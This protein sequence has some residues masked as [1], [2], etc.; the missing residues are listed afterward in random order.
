MS[1]H[2]QD[3]GL[4]AVRRVRAARE[5][6]SRLGLQQALAVL[7][8]RHADA[9]RA[10]ARLDDHGSFAAGSVGDFQLHA[11]LGAALA[12]ARNDADE[13]AQAGARVAEEA[14][15]RWR[16]DR[17]RVRAV[18]LLLERRSDERALLRRRREERDLDDLAAQG[19]LR[20][21]RAQATE[22]AT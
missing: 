18:D 2:E 14:A 9:A 22:A 16:A 4:A 20:R 17:A 8:D 13:R 3:R 15:N 5:R 11:V 12:A 7:A 1:T 6:D 19:W 21:T 10:A